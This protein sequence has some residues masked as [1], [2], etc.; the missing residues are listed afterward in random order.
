MSRTSCS[1][2]RRMASSEARRMLMRSMVS[3]STAAMAQA[4]AMARISMSS[5]LRFFSESFFESVRPCRRQP[6]GRMTAAATTGP[7]SGPRP[8]SSIPAMRWRAALARGFFQRPAADG[9]PCIEYRK[10]NPQPCGRGFC[11]KRGIEL[12][13]LRREPCRFRGRLRADGR[14]CRGV[15]EC[16]RAWRDAPCSCESSRSCR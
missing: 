14:L 2:A 4:T 1:T 15:R 16:R 9:L 11:L 13:Q 10:Q 7:K 5:S 6:W 3:T 8:T 12:W